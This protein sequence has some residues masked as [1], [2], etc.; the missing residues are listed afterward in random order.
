[1]APADVVGPVCESSDTFAR[2]RALPPLAPGALVAILDAG[3]YGAVMSSTYNAR[4]LAAEVL[5]DGGA[6]AGPDAG[7]QDGTG[8]GA[9]DRANIGAGDGARG[10]RR[11]AVRWA[12]IRPRQ[13]VATLWRDETVPDWLK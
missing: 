6:D 1:M 9:D 2:D 10:Q 7:P 3:A 11:P 13:D 8:V 12:V 5:V 4:P